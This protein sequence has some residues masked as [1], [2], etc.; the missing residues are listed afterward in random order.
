MPS[1][2]WALSRSFQSDYW[3]Q[4][5][6]SW[7]AWGENKLGIRYRAQAPR[8]VN[9]CFR[10][11]PSPSVPE[12]WNCPPP[13]AWHVYLL[14]VALLSHP[15]FSQ[16]P[17]LYILLCNVCMCVCVFIPGQVCSSAA[18]PEDKV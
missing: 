6:N 4:R 9:S 1:P 3:C 8:G 17:F 15:A 13:G 16:A 11:C 14:L 7:W 5:P 10:I 2:S 12:E 18:L